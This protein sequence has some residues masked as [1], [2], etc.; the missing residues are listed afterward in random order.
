MTIRIKKLLPSSVFRAKI[1]T[2]EGIILQDSQPEDNGNYPENL[3]TFTQQDI[4]YDAISILNTTEL[5]Y[6]IE[7]IFRTEKNFLLILSPYLKLTKKLV[8]ILS[9]SEASITIC[10][11]E[12]D[13]EDK[14]KEQ[15]EEINKLKKKLPDVN[16]QKIPD[17]H[18]KAYISQSYTII[19]SLNLYEH[20]Q[21]NNFELGVLIK[22]EKAR[23]ILNKL[24]NDIF[25]LFKSNN[26]NSTILDYFDSIILDNYS[27]KILDNSLEKVN[28]NDFYTYGNLYHTLKDK[29]KINTYPYKSFF[30]TTTT[31]SNTIKK[32]FK[33]NLWDLR[34]DETF[35]FKTKITKEIYDYCIEN[36]V[37]P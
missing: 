8:A 32:N 27:A 12:E 28:N 7:E 37:L 19:A 5:N 2:E 21:I 1:E 9:M 17:F 29:Y 33:F 24:K 18:A 10:Y 23:S 6:H 36:I 14:K 26:I 11:R 4:S 13:R 35:Y 30:N 31:I 34:D 22:N 15:E 3:S 25:I 16:F 20:S